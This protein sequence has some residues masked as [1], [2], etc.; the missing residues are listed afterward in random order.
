MIDFATFFTAL[1]GFEGNSVADLVSPWNPFDVRQITNEFRAAFARR[2]IEFLLDSKTSYSALG[3]RVAEAFV[4]SINADLRGYRLCGC[5]GQGYPDR[6]LLRLKDKR[7]FAFELKATTSFD[8]RNS[9]RV[10]L[11]SGTGK[12]RRNF[13]IANPIC[14]VLATTLYSKTQTGRRCQIMITGLRLDFLEPSS[15]IQKRYEASVSHWLLSRGAHE[16]RFLF[17]SRR[18]CSRIPSHRRNRQ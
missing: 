12:L 13:G 8:P 11:T 7:N 2:K 15:P 16:S 14:H 18:L 9:N 6:Q 17:P 1:S 10:I 3:N 5:K 4:D